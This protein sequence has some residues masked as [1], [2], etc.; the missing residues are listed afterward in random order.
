M[1]AE[2]LAKVYQEKGQNDSA[3]KYLRIAEELREKSNASLAKEQLL[4]GELLSEF[5]EREKAQEQA[6]KSGRIILLLVAVTCFL[7][8]LG[9]FWHAY[10]TGRKYQLTELA[11]MELEVSA[12]KNELEME[13]L[14]NEI[15]LKDRQLT[16]DVMSAI[17]KNEIIGNLVKKIQD[18]QHNS[19]QPEHELTGKII[20]E[21]E[22]TR[23]AGIWEDFELRFQQVYHD[24]YDNLHALNPSLTVNDRRLC[25]FLKLDMNT[26]EIA[27]ITGQSVRAV[28]LGRIRLRKKLGLTHSDSSIYEL[29][30][31]L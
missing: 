24:F 29:L 7:L 14:R 4:R 5:R 6:N 26:K 9:L 13:L 2:A 16:A 8:A 31:S 25:A 22:K 18:Q 30:A 27:T 17:R 11:R 12:R 1:L 28:E 15:E 3:L 10:R 20:S 23:E 19:G 21:L